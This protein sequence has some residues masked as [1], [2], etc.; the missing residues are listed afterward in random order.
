MRVHRWLGAAVV[1]GVLAAAAPAQ[2]Q[3]PAPVAAVCPALFHVLHDDSV[4]SLVLPQGRYRITTF[5]T[6]APNCSHASD[7]LRQF[8]EDWDGQL[9]RPWVVNAAIGGFTRGSG[10]TG[11][12]VTPAPPGTPDA[13]G[14]GRHPATGSDCPGLFQVLHT[15]FIGAVEVPAGWYRITVLSIGGLS[16]AQA[17]TL[18]A[19]FL[20]DFDG[21]LPGGWAL[22][23]GT[24]TFMQRNSPNTA[25][26][27][28]AATPS[29]PRNDD[30]GSHP[31]T[32]ANRCPAS[33]RVQNNDRIGALRLP[34]GRYR[35]TSYGRV[36]CTAAASLFTDFLQ[37][38]DGRLPRP[39]RLDADAGAFWRGAS[40]ANGFRAKPVRFR[41]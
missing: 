33:F 39:W 28:E 2:A 36:N 21:R 24:A 23:P 13:G 20:Q 35:I 12:T 34:A 10:T 26:R 29:E 8:L 14:G 3:T 15:D 25:F 41:S 32:G 27:V 40:Q 11:F 6:G 31:G 37:H 4:G 1:A 7:L 5:G 17:S 19:Q 30:R 38:P 9:K 16:C 18:F 22:D